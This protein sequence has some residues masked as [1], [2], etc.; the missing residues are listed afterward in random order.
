[1][2]SLNASLIA[3]ITAQVGLPRPASIRATEDVV[4]L[5]PRRPF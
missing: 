1:M 3:Q 5:R 4:M 2:D